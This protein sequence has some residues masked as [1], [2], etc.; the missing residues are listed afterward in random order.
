MDITIYRDM[1]KLSYQEVMIKMLGEDIRPK[2]E[3]LDM[4]VEQKDEF[5]EYLHTLEGRNLYAE[6]RKKLVKWFETIGVKLRRAGI[7]TLNGALQDYYGNK[8]KFRFRD[9]VLDENGKS[10]KKKLTDKR[11]TL[12]DGT[13]NPNRDKKYW[14]LEE[15]SFKS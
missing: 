12:P 8:Y 2:V 5:M 14:I 10:T 1:K 6:D 11:R 9:C 15:T 4:Y 13:Q 3:T 7:N